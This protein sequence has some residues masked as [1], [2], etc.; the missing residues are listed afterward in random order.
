M[1]IIK[2]VQ[3]VLGITTALFALKFT[4]ANARDIDS[5][6]CTTFIKYISKYGIGFIAAVCITSTTTSPIIPIVSAITLYCSNHI[7]LRHVSFMLAGTLFGMTITGLGPNIDSLPLS[8]VVLIISF[9]Y[10][11][12][13]KCIKNEQVSSLSKA[14]IG[15]IVSIIALHY[16]TE[17]WKLFAPEFRGLSEYLISNYSE[18]PFLY[19][20]I[21]STIAQSDSPAIGLIIMNTLSSTIEVGFALK[22]ITGISL[23]ANLFIYIPFF[24]ID[25]KAFKVFALSLALSLMIILVSLLLNSELL[26][27]IDSMKEALNS[28]L[29]ETIDTE[30]G[31]DAV[32]IAAYNTM[33][34]FC[35]AVAFSVIIAVV[36]QLKDRYLKPHS[37]MN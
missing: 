26:T 31:I 6:K 8:V 23:F 13:R 28:T 16:F 4:V 2:I 12:A 35:G 5:K 17:G 30:Q 20:V 18:Y 10:S 7:A 19:G 36:A 15:L 3:I 32:T 22:A 29:G 24:F 1:E 25:R 27:V 14:I 33:I 9:V 34:T 21:L 37:I 11:N